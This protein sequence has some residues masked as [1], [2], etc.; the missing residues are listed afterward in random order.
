MTTK[1]G[2]WTQGEIPENLVYQFLDSDGE[3]IPLSG[4]EGVFVIQKIGAVGEE[5]AVVVDEVA[6]HVTYAWVEADLA[7]VASFAGQF[8]VGNGEHRHASTDY[9]WDVE[10]PV[11]DI[12]PDL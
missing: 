9:E 3:A 10:P 1:I 2:P 7:E 8:W 11:A 6:N 5:R 12:I 4:F